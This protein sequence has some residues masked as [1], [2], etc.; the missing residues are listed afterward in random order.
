MK[1]IHRF[2]F[3]SCALFVLPFGAGA[4]SSLP[5]IPQ[6]ATSF[7]AA[8]ADG[9]LYI[10]GGNTGKA[11]FIPMNKMQLVQTFKDII[12]PEVACDVMLTGKVKPGMEERQR[13]NL[14]AGNANPTPPKNGPNGNGGNG[15]TAP[16]FPGGRGGRM[17]T[18]PPGVIITNAVIDFGD[19]T[20]QSL[21]GLTGT[22]TVPHD[23][24]RKG[25][26]VVTVTVT[27]SIGRNT[28]AQV[29]INIP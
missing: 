20:A 1:I 5:P 4:E 11:P 26:T 6:P 14:E 13:R 27:D 25:A 24:T 18:P 22:T 15:N 29:T 19:N 23:Y 17:M 7:G 16:T 21:G 3:A 8:I 2:F 9:W 28:T 12:G 10:Y